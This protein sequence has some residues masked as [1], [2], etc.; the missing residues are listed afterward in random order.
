MGESNKVVHSVRVVGAG[1]MGRGIAQLFATGGF[2]VSLMDRSKKA[3]DA[4]LWGIQGEWPTAIEKNILTQEQLQ[5]ARARLTICS[6]FTSWRNVDLVVE[7]IIEDQQAKEAL[8]EH[9]TLHAHVVSASFREH[10]L[11]HSIHIGLGGDHG[12]RRAAQSQDGVA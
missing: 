1:A 12:Q 2:S 6:D 3:L 10:G 8:L 11:L 5:Q 7:A 4:A 9:H